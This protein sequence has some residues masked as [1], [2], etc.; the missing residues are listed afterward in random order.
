MPASKQFNTT[1]DLQLANLLDRETAG[2]IPRLPK[3][4]VAELA[5]KRLVGDLDH[6]QL[7]LDLPGDDRG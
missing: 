6:G 5:L 1:I 4:Y 2:I 7:R 3:R